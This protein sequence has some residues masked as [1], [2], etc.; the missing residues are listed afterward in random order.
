MILFYFFKI[1]FSKVVCPRQVKDG[2][3]TIS[4]ILGGVPQIESKKHHHASCECA[5]FPQVMETL[6]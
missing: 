6:L 4:K 2:V 1:F 5:H 3:Q